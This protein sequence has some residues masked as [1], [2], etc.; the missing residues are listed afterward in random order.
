M[1]GRRNT[2]LGPLT[3]V[4]PQP[5]RRLT[6]QQAAV[7]VPRRRNTLPRCGHLVTFVGEDTADAIFTGSDE[8]G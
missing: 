4:V 8:R 7:A 1:R 3:V 2:D 6:R 5:G